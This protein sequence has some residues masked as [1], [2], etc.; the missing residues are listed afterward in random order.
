M[1]VQIGGTI[2]SF[3]EPTGLLSDCH[4][5]VEKFL[6]MLQAVATG[7]D[8]PATEETKCALQLA[9]HYFTEAAPKHTADEEESLF[10]RLRQLHD[11]EV[12]S[13][14]S[15]LDQLEGDHRWAGPL[16]TA[17]EQ[18]GEKYLS[19]GRLSEPEIGRF[20]TSVANLIAMYQRHIRIEDEQIFPL[21][22]RVLSRDEKEAV[23]KEMA[24]RRGIRSGE[25]W[26]G[27]GGS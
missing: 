26:H 16:H 3:R 12:E 15:R 23:A 22:A 20:R 17:V 11:P 1:P 14:L 21:A 6:G 5:R 27:R 25:A 24:A 9:L 8:Q 7:I 10:P 2:H 18:L 19:E 13:A 4:R